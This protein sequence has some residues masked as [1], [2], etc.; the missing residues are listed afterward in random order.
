MRTHEVLPDTKPYFICIRKDT[1]IRVGLK[2]RKQINA[3]RGCWT[4][5]A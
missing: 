2:S 4:G 5:V 1:V 3:E